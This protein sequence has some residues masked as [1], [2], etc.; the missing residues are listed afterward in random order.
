MTKID[1]ATLRSYWKEAEQAADAA[2]AQNQPRTCDHPA[3]M[4]AADYRAPKNRQQ[5]NEFYW[6]CLPH[7]QE[8]NKS[9]NYYQGMSID[10]MED[11]RRQDT[12]GWRPTWPLG[13]LRPGANGEQ[14]D[15]NR[16][17]TEALRAKIFRDFF[18]GKGPAG[19]SA[20]ARSR[21]GDPAANDGLTV[22]ERGAFSQFGLALKASWYEVKQRYRE[23]AKAY[24]P[25]TRQDDA[26][27]AEEQLKNINRAYAV[28]KKRFQKV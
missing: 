5:L 10:Q 23:L 2:P 11:V 21:A 22:E 4:A 6:F 24:H 20:G 16:V 28:L 7:V 25:D 17:T 9:W 1:P 14:F 26:A 13:T 15:A 18:G 19:A 12:V 27:A 3:C 8:Y